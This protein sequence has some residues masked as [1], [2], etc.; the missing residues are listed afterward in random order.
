MSP[1]ELLD[2]LKA[3]NPILTQAEIG[4][5]W[6]CEDASRFFPDFIPKSELLSIYWVNSMD[7]KVGS[8]GTIVSHTF[9][10]EIQ[11]KTEITRSFIADMEAVYATELAIK[12][13]MKNDIISSDDVNYVNNGQT[14]VEIFNVNEKVGDC[15]RSETNVGSCVC[16]D[17]YV[18]DWEGKCILA[19]K[20]TVS[21]ER[22]VDVQTGNGPEEKGIMQCD[23]DHEIRVFTA[24]LTRRNDVTCSGG[25]ITDTTHPNYIKHALKRKYGP[26]STEHSVAPFIQDKCDGNESCEYKYYEGEFPTG[27]RLYH[28]LCKPRHKYVTIAYGCSKLDTAP[29]P[30]EPNGELITINRCTA[31]ELYN[32]TLLLRYLQNV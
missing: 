20:T 29:V 25:K 10:I 3:D 30:Q 22:S 9:E 11:L 31:F 26:C 5:D 8:N 27:H 32:L 14:D 19:D 12:R 18:N 24:Y 23:S 28:K 17:G 13:A 4:T 21:C 16:I 15:F 1:S 6:T 2:S 7:A